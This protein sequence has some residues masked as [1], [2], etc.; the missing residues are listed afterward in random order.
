MKENKLSEKFKNTLENSTTLN[1][2]EGKERLLKKR[3]KI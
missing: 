3:V 1:S 2:D